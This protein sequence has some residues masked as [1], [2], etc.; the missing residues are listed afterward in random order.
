MNRGVSLSLLMALVCLPGLGV[1]VA[2]DN[3]DLYDM[4]LEELMEVELTGAA[5]RDLGLDKKPQTAN[6]FKQS[7]RDLPLSIDVMSRQTMRARGLKSVTE[8]ADQLVG[9][10][11]GE[12][13][14]EPSSFSI[15]GFTRD[16]VT[17]LRDGIKLG[18][19][20]MTM[21]PHNTFN[22]RVVDLFC[23]VTNLLGQD[24]KNGLDLLT[25]AERGQFF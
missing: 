25:K 17:I 16:S 8:A 3:E 11:S 19:A 14:A 2:Q 4:A 10:I 23:S 12:S 6:P 15:R 9:V 7:A 22:L 24:I 1:A 20:T 21:R 13:P 18:P 5:V